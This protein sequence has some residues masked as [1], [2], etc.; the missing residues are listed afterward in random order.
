MRSIVSAQ[1]RAGE[2][3]IR[4]RDISLEQ[5]FVLGYLKDNPGA[6]QRD[7][8]KKVKRG[9]ANVSA[10]LQRLEKRGLVERRLEG[11]DS[12]SKRVYATA[13]GVALITGLDTAMAEVDEIILAPLSKSERSVLLS[14]LDRVTAELPTTPRQ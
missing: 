11:G 3:W 2:A 10:M 1:L 8:A 4:E 6:I 5:G 7:I 9:E 13:E 14:L 12:R